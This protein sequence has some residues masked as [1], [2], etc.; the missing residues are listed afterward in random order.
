MK[1]IIVTLFAFILCNATPAIATTIL[2]EDISDGE[3]TSPIKFSGGYNFSIKGTFTGTITSQR[4]FGVYSSQTGE[5]EWEVDFRDINT[6]TDPIELRE[7][8][9]EIEWQITQRR[10][11]YT[12]TGT[13]NIRYGRK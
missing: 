4:R 9:E 12:G 10:E 6:F 3:C 11:C 2:Q 7:L 13:A 8:P 5:T 1:W